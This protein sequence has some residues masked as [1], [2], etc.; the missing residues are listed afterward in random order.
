MKVAIPSAMPGGLEA[1]VSGHFGHCEA[2]TIVTLADG[3][4]AGIE[5]ADN[6]HDGPHAC[7]AT[8]STLIDRGIEVL[9]VGGIGMRPLSLLRGNGIAVHSTQ[10]ATVGEAVEAFIRGELPTFPDSH[11]CGGSGSCGRH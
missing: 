6:R 10:A 9:I 5:V 11:V 1:G 3:K 7:G 8:V 2:F 4:V